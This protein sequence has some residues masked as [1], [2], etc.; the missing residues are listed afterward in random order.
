MNENERETGVVAW[1]NIE[2]GYGFIRRDEGSPDAF[3]HYSQI[4]TEEE[5]IYRVLEKGARVEFEVNLT[6]RDD[7]S[8]KL[9]A[10]NIKVIG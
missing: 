10:K 1:F 6:A 8:E 4:V 5:G 7:G 2:R 3:A 9:Q